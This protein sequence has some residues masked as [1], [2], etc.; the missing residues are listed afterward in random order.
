MRTTH[1]CAAALVALC[2]ASTIVD[3]QV[4]TPDSSTARDSAVID[5]RLLYHGYGYGSDAYYSPVTLLLN[6]GFDI[7][8]LRHSARSISQ[9]QV[10][11]AW[12]TGVRGS[13]FSP[14][15]A[16][17]RFGGWGRL[18]RVELLPIDWKPAD[19]NWFAN[20][21]E[22]LI[23]GGL[24]MRM[25]SEWYD[26]HGFPLPR[27]WGVATTYGASILNEI[28]EQPGRT[29]PI[30]G[31]VAD[32]L[33]FDVAAITLFHWD[34][35]THFFAKTIEASDWENQASFTYPNHQLQNNGQY[36][37]LK[38]P[39]GLENTRLFI[40][41]G[42][43]AQFGI[44][45]KLDAENR[46]SV[47]VGG[48]TR[49]RDI[50]AVGHETVKFSPAGGVYY[51]RNNSL[52]AS[53]TVSP[54]ENVLAVNVYPGVLPGLARDVGVWSVYT[55]DNQWRFGIVQRRMLGLGAGWGR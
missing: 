12:A 2:V 53:V 31:E 13:L 25:M 6:K 39:I 50:D 18:A 41:G 9:L 20:Y 51:D 11:L 27:L 8:Q 14:G 5:H 45:Q 3:A 49:V 52:L 54:A 28:S 43:G 16:V 23:G 7:F 15:P 24:S 26:D 47:G 22:H 10:G 37:T 29:V 30:A 46:I 34:Q 35:P 32:I 17:E 48:D 21:T 33:F 38:V 36:W 1:R 55:R 19:M 42:M 4:A 40:R 44:A